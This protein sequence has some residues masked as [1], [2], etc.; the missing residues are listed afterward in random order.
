MKIKKSSSWWDTFL[1]VGVF[2]LVLMFLYQLLKLWQA[3][4]ATVA[5]LGTSIGQ[6]LTN[7]VAAVESGL[8][9]LLTSPAAVFSSLFSSIPDLLTLFFSFI[10]SVS[11]AGILSG[12]ASFITNLFGGLT[13]SPIVA[14][15]GAS[16]TS[17][18]SPDPNLGGNSLSPGAGF[19]ASSS[20]L[21]PVMQ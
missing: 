14:G 8:S 15:A 4:T 3:G 16:A 13:A 12:L 18:G 10:G 5:N 11:F 17:T 7:T 2:I 9:G 19:S 1:W 6:A 21:T 20:N